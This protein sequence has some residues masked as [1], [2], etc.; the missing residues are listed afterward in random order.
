MD[1]LACLI[2]CAR[3]RGTRTILNV[4]LEETAEVRQ[5]SIRNVVNA[6]NIH[7]QLQFQRVG[8]G[9]SMSIEKS[10]QLSPQRFDVGLY[11]HKC[12]VIYFQN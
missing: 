4:L 12:N 5:I 11:H 1:A 9:N 2:G 8:I 7:L 10:H 3:S 6:H